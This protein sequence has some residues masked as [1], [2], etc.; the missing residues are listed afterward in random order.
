M[1]ERPY[2]ADSTPPRPNGAVNRHRARL[3]VQDGVGPRRNPG[4]CSFALLF[5]YAT[6]STLLLSLD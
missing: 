4:C 6:P 2:H 5:L 3:I 1:W